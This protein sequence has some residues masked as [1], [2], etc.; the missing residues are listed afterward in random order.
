MIPL[1]SV[2]I[3]TIGRPQ[4]LPRAINSAL[5]GMESKDI[6]LIVIPNGPD[7]SWQEALQPYHNNQSVRVIP[8]VE[9][10]ANIARNVGLD[11]ARGEFVRFLDDDDYLIQ[12]G[13]LKQYALIKSSNV[14]VVSGSVQLV[15]EKGRCFDT[16]YQPNMDD[17]CAAV[18]GPWRK[19]H[20]SAFVFKR[21]SLGNN[22]W[23]PDIAVR[24]DFDWLFNLCVSSELSW[25][26]INDVVG[27]WQ[28]H[29]GQQVSSSKNFN[30]IRKLTV[31]MLILAYN[32]LLAYGRLNNLRQKAISQGL[33]SCVH[34]AFFLE[35]IYWHR[36][37][38]MAREIDSTIRPA[39]ALYSYP[40]LKHLNP[41]TIIWL[42]LPVKWLIYLY[43]QILKKL[44]IRHTW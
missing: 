5:S 15:D 36:I 31:P 11:E 4:Y 23:N 19:C 38:Y 37:A 29:W 6:E 40:V 39:Q 12:I 14:D 10:N 2:I 16:W 24:Q 32:K 27:I 13:V 33:W 35:P 42:I 8:I 26:K 28:H 18:L 22:R 9:A 21:K 25:I 7:D 17:F 1:V 41:L 43:R 20:P 3:P 44:H 34:T 30:E